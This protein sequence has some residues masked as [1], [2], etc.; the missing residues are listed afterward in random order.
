MIYIT[1]N[2]ETG[3]VDEIAF[4]LLEM[5]PQ[6]KT[7]LEISEED[8]QNSN[9]KDRKVVN[10]QFTYKDFPPTIEDYDKIMEEHLK[11]ERIAR[12]YTLREPSDYKDDPYERFAQ[13]AIDW[14]NHRSEVMVYGLNIQNIYKE[15]G[16]A[17][18]LEEFKNNLPKINWTFE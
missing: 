6:G 18:S 8:W 5:I 14:I 16:E 13:D 9:G 11:E 10:G 17:P 15:T 4:S 2:N 12:G 3:K 7:Y 1:Y